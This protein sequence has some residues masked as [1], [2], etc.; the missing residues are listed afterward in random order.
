MNIKGRYKLFKSFSLHLRNSSYQQNC[1]NSFIPK[2]WQLL[3]LSDGSF[4]QT[5]TSLT[6]QQIYLDQISQ[7]TYKLIN[8]LYKVRDIW[9]KDHKSNQLIFAKSLWLLY[10]SIDLP[11]AQPIGKSLILYQKD[12]YRDIHELYYGYC[13]YLESKFHYKGP[14]WGRKYTIYYNQEPL[15]T[16]QEVFAPLVI[17]CFNE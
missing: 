1:V 9:L 6:G 10:F 3:L 14:V 11:T 2:E 8:D 5:L 13:T 17:N 12:I 16:L 15:T 4:T 7:Y